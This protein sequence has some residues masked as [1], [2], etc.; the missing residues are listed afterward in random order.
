MIIRSE[1]IDVL[2]VHQWD[3]FRQRVIAHLHEDF[4]AL[5]EQRKLDYA[6]INLLVEEGVEHAE[7]YGI[8]GEDDV[9]RFIEYLVEYGEGFDSVPWAASVLKDPALSGD[10]KM[11]RLDDVTAFTLR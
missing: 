4:E 3:R 8:S 6:G 10:Q 1:Q 7:T 5:L 9:T 11:D 2:E